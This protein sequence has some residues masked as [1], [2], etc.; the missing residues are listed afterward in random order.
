MGHAITQKSDEA[1][2]EWVDWFNHR[3]LLGPIGNVLGNPGKVHWRHLET[4]GMSGLLYNGCWMEALPM[5]RKHLSKRAPRTAVITLAIA[6]AITGACLWLKAEHR[7][8]EPVHVAQ[9][10]VADLEVG[11]FA[12]A[13]AL[14]MKNQYTGHTVSELADISSHNLCQVQAGR[15]LWM[16]PFQ[17]NGNRLRRW[18]MG[19]EV[20][21]PRDR[22]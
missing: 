4:S 8:S 1:C 18:L 2:L 10:F 20:E 15:V 5:A 12:Q 7:P 3:R 9:A 11:E 22:N 16:S 13:Y 14:T 6:C 21:M 19:R 17:S